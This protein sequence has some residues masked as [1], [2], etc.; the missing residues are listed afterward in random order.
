MGYIFYFPPLHPDCLKIIVKPVRGK[1]G[2]HTYFYYWRCTMR[3]VLFLIMLLISLLLPSSTHAQD[4]QFL[5]NVRVQILPEYDKPAVLVI[6]QISLS[7]DTHLPTTLDLRIPSQA[8]VYAVAIFNPETGLI[9]A[10]YERTLHGDWATLTITTSALEIQV[11]YYEALEKNGDT[12]QISYEWE[13]NYS[14][15][16]FSVIFQEPVG[17]LELTTIPELTKSPSAQD[18]FY[19]YQSEPQSIEKGESY[20]LIVDYRK[21]SDT[22][23]T[24]GLSVEPSQPLDTNTPGRVTTT[25]SLP[26]ILSF[27]GFILLIII[28]LMGGLYIWKRDARPPSTPKKHHRHTVPSNE[29]NTFHCQNCGKQSQPGDLFCRTCGS[30]LRKDN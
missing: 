7:L 23:S 5:R 11:E 1:I 21:G 27:T 16:S 4:D 6:Y 17:A 2:L 18:G 26:L 30:R 3:K 9:N 22:L 8:E 13:S 24:T 10:P 12:R 14:V 29:S 15:D 19:Y 20:K 28:G 25:G